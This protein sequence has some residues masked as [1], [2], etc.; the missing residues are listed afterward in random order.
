M[1]VGPKGAFGRP[2]RVADTVAGNRTLCADGTLK[3]HNKDML[4]NPSS[5]GPLCSLL[6]GLSLGGGDLSVL[7]HYKIDGFVIGFRGDRVGHIDITRLFPF[8]VYPPAWE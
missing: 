2:V 1:Q 7:R 3:S 6:G 5:D 4:L 8:A